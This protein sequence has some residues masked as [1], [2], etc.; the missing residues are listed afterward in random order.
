MARADRFVVVTALGLALLS[1]LMSVSVTA[2][3]PRSALAGA[4]PAMS[5][6]AD[7]A[8]ASVPGT[9]AP[10]VPQ[11]LAFPGRAKGVAL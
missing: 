2:A 7:L 5:G 4:R 9:V 3:E 10:A 8:S 11:A 6:T 1:C